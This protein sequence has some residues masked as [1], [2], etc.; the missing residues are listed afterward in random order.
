MVHLDFYKMPDA[1]RRFLHYGHGR[2]N[3]EPFM[4]PLANLDLPGL[5]EDKGFVDIEISSFKED[6]AVD[7][8]TNDAWRFPWTVISAVKPA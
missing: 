5:L 2:R 4:Q 6:E 7:L 1:F 8:K 3:N